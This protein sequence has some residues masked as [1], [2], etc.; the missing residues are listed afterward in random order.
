MRSLLALTISFS[1]VS[2][3]A[4]GQEENAANCF[5]LDYDKNAPIGV[6]K[7]VGSDAKANFIKSADDDKSCPAA[8]QTCERKAYLRPGDVVTT[9]R[10]FGAFTCVSYVNAKQK[11]T[12]GWIAT[13][14]LEPR[15]PLS[16]P[17]MSDWLGKWYSR[18]D[19]MEGDIEIT[20]GVKRGFF[21]VRGEATYAVTRDNVRT[22]D[23]A[24]DNL[25]PNVA[26][27]AFV[28]GGEKAFDKA[29][30][31]DC[32][33]RMSRIDQF[34]LVEDN[35]YCGGMAVTFTGLYHR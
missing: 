28:D 8:T 29:G 7:I 13:S 14:A 16:A 24:I 26:T 15:P 27:H 32:A 11:E 25:A 19:T 17:K 12:T 23:F 21:E 2:L 5:A 33:V 18:R 22:G 34:L 35:G 4:I 20:R 31:G 3:V 1:L 6:A 30:E 10:A 9:G